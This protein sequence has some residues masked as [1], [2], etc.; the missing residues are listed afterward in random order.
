MKPWASLFN[1]HCS[2]SHSCMTEYL[3]IDSGGYFYKQS[4][5]INCGM[6][7]YF[8]GKL[9]LRLTEQVCQGSKV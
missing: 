2:S 3:A 4:L 1:L 5:C 8:P 7:G 9:R 6:A